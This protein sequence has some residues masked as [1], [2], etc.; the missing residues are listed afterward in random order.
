[1][2]FVLLC[3]VV[4]G[5]YGISGRLA[6]N[7]EGAENRKEVWAVS[8]GKSAAAGGTRGTLKLYAGELSVHISTAKLRQTYFVIVRYELIPECFSIMFIR[9][10][11]YVPNYC[12]YH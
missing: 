7:R 3:V 2:L 9:P 11:G 12:S 1:M 4:A 10:C 8:K 6:G 5:L